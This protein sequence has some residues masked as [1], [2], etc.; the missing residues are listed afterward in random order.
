MLT[1]LFRRIPVLGK[2]SI[3]VLFVPKC[4]NYQ[5]LMLRFKRISMLTPSFNFSF[6]A[7]IFRLVT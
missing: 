3:I 1:I 6:G 4:I 7:N 2:C 5:I